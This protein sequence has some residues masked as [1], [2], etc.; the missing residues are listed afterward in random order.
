M[1]KENRD[2]GMSRIVKIV[3]CIVTI[4]VAIFG[5]YVIL[6]GH[7]T[8]GGGFPGGAIIATLIALFLV[9]FGEES[10]SKG[11]YKESFSVL[12]CLGITLF[13]LLAF[14]GISKTFFHNFLANSNGIFGNIIPF[15]SNPGYLNTGG[16]IPLMNW[17]VGLEVLSALSLIILLMFIVSNGGEK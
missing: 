15:G 4:P 11:L 7:L 16:I 13:A 9:A 3:T 12:E 6:H 5:L 14:I 1:K 8:P 10:I 17:A 2:K